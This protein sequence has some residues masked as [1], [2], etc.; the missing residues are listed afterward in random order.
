MTW[1]IGCSTNPPTATGLPRALLRGDCGGTLEGTNGL[2]TCRLRRTVP[3]RGTPP[4]F[5][6]L[7]ALDTVLPDLEKPSKAGVEKAIQGTTGA[8]RTIGTYHKR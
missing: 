7:Y 2:Q 4:L 1:V 6:K 8:R 3:A 5:H